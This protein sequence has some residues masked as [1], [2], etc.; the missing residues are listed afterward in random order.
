MGYKALSDV[1]GILG[2]YTK[3]NAQ[4][5]TYIEIAGI[6]HEKYLTTD[7]AENVYDWKNDDKQFIRSHTQFVKSYTDIQVPDDIDF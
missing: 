2:K 1:D 3:G 7:Y 6:T 4:T 5:P